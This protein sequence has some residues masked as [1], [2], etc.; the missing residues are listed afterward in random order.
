MF[1][2]SYE[3]VISESSQ[4]KQNIQIFFYILKKGFLDYVNVRENI[5]EIL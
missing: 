4:N 3:N 1:P 2:L 5:K